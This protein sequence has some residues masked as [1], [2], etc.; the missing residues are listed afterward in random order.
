MMYVLHYHKNP[1]LQL[2][3]LRQKNKK[4]KKTFNAIIFCD[5]P[6]SQRARCTKLSRK[7]LE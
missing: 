4:Q 6:V 7:K 1:K 3:G 2:S 5:V